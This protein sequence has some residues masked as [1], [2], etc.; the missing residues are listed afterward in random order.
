[1]NLAPAFDWCALFGNTRQLVLLS[2]A[3]ATAERCL[4]RFVGFV[5][6]ILCDAKAMVDEVV[7]LKELND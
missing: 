4:F 5:E 3:I 2:F 1:M 6:Q 7:V